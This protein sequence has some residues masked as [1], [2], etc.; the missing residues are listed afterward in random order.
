MKI[1][2]LCS[3]LVFFALFFGACNEKPVM[4][5]E[6]E[7][8]VTIEELES[9]IVSLDSN[10]W[11]GEYTVYA[12][13]LAIIT[14]DGRQTYVT[15][16]R[17]IDDDGNIEYAYCANMESPCYDKSRY[18]SVP[19]GDYFVKEEPLKIKAALTYIMNNYGWMETTN[20]LG[21]VQMT[22]AI[23][24]MIIHD[25]KLT[26]VSNTNDAALIRD[27]VNYIYDNLDA[28]SESYLEGITVQGLDEATREGAYIYYGPYFISK[29]MLLTDVSFDLT[30]DPD[31]SSVVF[32][33]EAGTEITQIKPEERFYMRAPEDVAGDFNI[34]IAISTELSYVDDFRFFVDVRDGDYQQLF[35]PVV[36]PYSWVNFYSRSESITLSPT[37]PPLVNT[38]GCMDFLTY[39]T[40]GKDNVSPL[41]PETKSVLRNYAHPIVK[42]LFQLPTVKQA[43]NNVLKY[44]EITKETELFIT[45]VSEGAMWNNA[46]GYFV[47][48]AEVAKTDAA[49]YQYWLDNVKPQMCTTAGKTNVLKERFA[50][51]GIIFKNVRDERNGGDMAAGNVYQIGKAGKKFKP[52]DRI[53]IF[54]CPNGWN[55]EYDRVEVTFSSGTNRQI[56]FMHKYF[57]EKTKILYGESYGDFEGVQIMSFYSADCKSVVLGIEDTANGSDMDFNDII[58]TVS[59]NTLHRAVTSFKAPAWAIGENIGGQNGLAIVP[60]SE[61][62]PNAQ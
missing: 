17:L 3:Y 6:D 19:P 31:G 15:R 43:A 52:G 26:G 23:I 8:E 49:E 25:Y 36:T 39:M 47:I 14:I 32:V 10:D 48:P 4:E 61:V 51:G 33:N 41:F 1:K 57:N 42:Q 27:A 13:S 40:I 24:W 54:M 28:I 35:Q 12:G 20:P 55:E 11:G 38:E 60:T 30:I 5:E 16:F 53:V 34:N 59:D 46:L 22:Q 62:N 50:C 37:D 45:Y 58:F 2:V 18:K 56:L 29:N 7:D 9:E 21:Y 44:I